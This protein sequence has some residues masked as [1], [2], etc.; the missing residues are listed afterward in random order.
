MSVAMRSKSSCSRRC[1]SVT[2]IAA[3]APMRW[4]WLDRFTEFVSGSQA[5]A[6]KGVSLSEDHLHDH[7]PS[8]PV[9]P[10][11]LVAE[12]MAQAAACW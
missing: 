6:V 7:W 9:M 10:N 12:G 5:T 11:S 8:Y 3:L 2:S 4:F 1:R